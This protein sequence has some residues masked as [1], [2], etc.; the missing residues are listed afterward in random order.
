MKRRFV[1]F[2]GFG[3]L[4]ALPALGLA[5]RYEDGRARP[6]ASLIETVERHLE[7][8][9]SVA[10]W[11]RGERHRA[12]EALG[13]LSNFDQR[14]HQGRFDKGQLGEAIEHIQGVLS[15]NRMN[16]RQR[17]LLAQDVDALRRFRASRGQG[18]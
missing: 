4:L 9:E 1:L 5:Q 18:Y 8:A 12:D 13:H 10:Y 7:H 17:D 14:W 6:G 3:L 15:H 2:S 11:S 16:E